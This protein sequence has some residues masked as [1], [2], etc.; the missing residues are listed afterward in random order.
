VTQA[1]PGYAVFALAVL[2]RM[3]WPWVTWTGLLVAVALIGVSILYYS[4]I[5][6]PQRQPGPIDWLEDKRSPRACC[7]SRSSCSW[8]SFSARR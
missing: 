6:L 3:G 8:T 7:S 1:V 5:M 2:V 4:P